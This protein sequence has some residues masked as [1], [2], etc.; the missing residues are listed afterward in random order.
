MNNIFFFIIIIFIL[1]YI[2]HYPNYKETFVNNSIDLTNDQI[3]II[4]NLSPHLIAIKNLGDLSRSFYI[5][6]FTNNSL[7]IPG[8]LNIIGDLNVD[9]N[10]NIDGNVVIGKDSTTNGKLNNYGDVILNKIN[11]YNNAT[12]NGNTNFANI[13]ANNLTILNNLNINNLKLNENSLYDLQNTQIGYFT[14]KASEGNKL[15][16]VKFTKPFKNFP[17]VILALSHWGG[18]FKSYNGYG[19]GCDNTTPIT[20]NNYEFCC[21][22]NPGNNYGSDD[23]KVDMVWLAIGSF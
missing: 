15:V 2:Y 8:N 3:N 22:I 5:D 14:V 19:S 7:I 17:R 11:V 18:L 21:T 13:S 10:L 12:F 16:C 23:Y 9:G 6:N 20:V 4:N 1:Y